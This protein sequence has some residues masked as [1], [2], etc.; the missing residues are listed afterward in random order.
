MEKQNKDYSCYV[1]F[2]LGIIFLYWIFCSWKDSKIEEKS[3]SAYCGKI[4][5]ERV[6]YYM[7]NC[8]DLKNQYEIDKCNSYLDEVYWRMD[9]NMIQSLLDEWYR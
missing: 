3:F 7:K 9:C 2:I 6:E 1:F 4:H 5:N 8:K